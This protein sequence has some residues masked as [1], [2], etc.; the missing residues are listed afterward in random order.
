MQDITMTAIALLESALAEKGKQSLSC[1]PAS[2][3]TALETETTALGEWLETTTGLYP[4]PANRI[5]AA[6]VRFHADK[7]ISDAWQARHLCHGCLVLYSRRAPWLMEDA[8][9]FP[10]LLQYVDSLHNRPR[11]FRR[12]FQGLMLAYFTYEPGRPDPAAGPYHNRETGWKNRLLL[13]AFLQRRRHCIVA[14]DVNPDWVQTVMAHPDLFSP[15][16]CQAYVHAALQQDFSAFNTLC[17]RLKISRASW[18]ARGLVYEQVDAITRKPDDEFRRHL[19]NSIDLLSRHSWSAEKGLKKL[20]NRYAASEQTEANASLRD[21]SISQ[22]KNPWLAKEASG[23]QSV[24]EQARKMVSAWTKEHLIRQFF[25]I[26]AEGTQ[27][28]VRRAAF[29]SRYFHRLEALYFALGSQAS[30][31]SSRD[32]IRLRQAMEGFLLGLEQ[33]GR[34]D[35]N[36]CIFMIGHYAI[37]EF[38][39]N[40]LPAY[41]YD[42]R[43][44]LPFELRR[45]FRITGSE[46]RNQRSAAFV[47]MLPHED[48]N[49]TPWEAIF[50]ET[51]EQLHIRAD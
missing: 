29:W 47:Q 7:K 41:I 46:L 15:N 13:R 39:A 37:V 4:P 35:R 45:G 16:P 40:H 36:A 21:F 18:F 20:I 43:A 8:R 12:C 23:W 42:R 24:S 3:T 14:P 10:L 38:G 17:S 49:D 31:N 19:T 9:A 22:W 48:T 11:L 32:F 50:A 1:L 51:L 25:W 30:N 6:L 28:D 34:T 2:D 33:A 26:L 44:Q 27:Y 5:R